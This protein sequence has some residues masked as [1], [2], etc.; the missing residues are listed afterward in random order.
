MKIFLSISLALI[1]TFSAASATQKCTEACQAAKKYNCYNPD[2]CDLDNYLANADLF[3][4]YNK[5]D[6]QFSRYKF[7]DFQ[8]ELKELK[9]KTVG[10][11][12]SLEYNLRHYKES[13]HEIEEINQKK[14]I[15]LISEFGPAF[16]R[17]RTENYHKYSEV[18]ELYEEFEGSEYSMSVTKSPLDVL[19][20]DLT[21]NVGLCASYF[22]ENFDDRMRDLALYPTKCDA[23]CLVNFQVMYAVWAKIAK[24][25]A[26]YIHKTLNQ[27]SNCNKRQRALK[28][29]LY[30][31]CKPYTPSMY[32]LVKDYVDF[33]W[34]DRVCDMNWFPVPKH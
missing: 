1:M 16:K 19:G 17:Y 21:K 18:E 6:I 7:R 12:V 10:P 5:K 20:V 31:I 34:K 32:R 29:W 27:I 4:V 24:Q 14:E 28:R 33:L 26:Q 8:T 23:Q 30:D 25:L 2:K 9:D 22:E 13:L 11:A 3:M 15:E